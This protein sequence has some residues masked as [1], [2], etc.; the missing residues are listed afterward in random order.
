MGVV[1]KEAM[2]KEVTV[3]VV[4]LQWKADLL[5]VADVKHTLYFEHHYSKLHTLPAECSH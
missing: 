1:L 5:A 4:Q 2:L 3:M